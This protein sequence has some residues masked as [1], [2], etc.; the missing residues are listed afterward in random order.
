MTATLP[1]PRRDR[2]LEGAL[3]FTFVM[4]GLAM[5]GMVALLLPMM[6]GGGTASD[7]ERVALLAAHPW[8]FRLG[9]LPWQITAL[10]DGLLGVALLRARWVPRLPAIV[11]F[12][13]TLAAVLPDQASQLVWIT[14]G[15]DAASDAVRRGDLAG[16]LALERTLFLGTAALGAGLYTLGGVA[17]CWCFAGAGT[18]NRALTR[19]SVALYGIFFVVSLA[20]AL[21]ASRRPSSALVAAGNALGFVLLELWFAL[22][23]E[24]VLRRSRP[25]SPHG[26]DALWRHPGR[27]PLG[28][29]LDLVAESRFLRAL[30][31]L[32]PVVAF[33]SDIREVVYVSY[34]VP[35]SRLLG[36][37]P[38]G[39]DLDRLGPERDHALFTF[40]SYR[41]GHFGPRRLGPFRRLMPSPVQSNWRV[42]VVDPRT[43]QRGIY[44]VTSAI[45]TAVHALGAR[46]MSEGMPMHVLAHGEVRREEN[47][48]VHLRIDPGAGSGPDATATLRPTAR[49]T[50]PPPFDACFDGFEAFLACCVPQD[51]AMSTQPWWPRVTRQEI[52]LGIPLSVCERLDGEVVSRAASAIVGEAQALCFRVPEVSFTFSGEEH[53]PLEIEA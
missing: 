1:I 50:L 33:S 2:L 23:T 14:T 25:V 17:W 44:F 18:W 7:A 26:R 29:A 47:G 51:R 35:A 15:I 34:L 21:P 27:G 6:P 38:R 53:D 4:H 28:R 39:L 49:T 22:V 48:T 20:P 45:T 30:C 52:D 16:Y 19:L 41:H 40:L 31:E 9:W 43:G 36:L 8:R 3:L 5:L 37:V 24:A 42:H 46:L 10:S 11:A 32:S 12:I 13:L